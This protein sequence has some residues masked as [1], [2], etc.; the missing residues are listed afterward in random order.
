MQTDRAKFLSRITPSIGNKSLLVSVNCELWEMLLYCVL[1]PVLR[2]GSPSE[3][4]PNTECLNS[5]SKLHLKLAVKCLPVKLPRERPLLD[6]EFS[7]ESEMSRNIC[8]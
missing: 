5:G 1:R 6:V 3:L 8:L 2:L 4:P 7:T